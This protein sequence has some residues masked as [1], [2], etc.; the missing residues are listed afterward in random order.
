MR[1]ALA[2]FAALT[3]AAPAA[4]AT[5]SAKPVA[6]VSQGRIIARDIV[7]NC[8]PDACQGSTEES[9]PQVLCQSLAKRTGRLSSFIANGHAFAPAELDKCNG[10]APGGPAPALAEAR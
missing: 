5:Y 9:R 3:V 4:A 8:G 2:L 1:S 10:A 7:W 6:P